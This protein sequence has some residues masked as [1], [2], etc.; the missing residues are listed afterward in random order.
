MVHS[1]TELHKAVIHVIILLSYLMWRVNTLEKTLMLGKIESRRRR[2]R[3]RM[4]LLDGT[5]TSMDMSLSKH[6]EI[7]KDR[8]TWRAAVH[9]IPK[10]QTQFTDWTTTTCPRYLQS[11]CSQIGKGVQQGCVLSPCLFNLYAQYITWNARLDESQAAT[12]IAGRNISHLRLRRWYHANGR[13]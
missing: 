7:V 9:G 10:S 13:K 3:Q 12:K 11:P 5:T 6:W 1:F 2:G 4:R 8:E